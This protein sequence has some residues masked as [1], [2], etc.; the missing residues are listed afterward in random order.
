MEKKQQLKNKINY[1]YEMNKLQN[2][3]EQQV[4]DLV[5]K[6][7]TDNNLDKSINDIISG[8]EDDFKA[9]L[10]ARRKKIRL[11]KSDMMDNNR[12]EKFENVI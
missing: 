6:A 1:I 2:N 3:S 4:K 10:E 5:K 7:E 12:L 11:N 8:Q 9:K